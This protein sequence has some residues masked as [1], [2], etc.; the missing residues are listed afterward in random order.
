M[1]N[2][3]HYHNLESAEDRFKKKFREKTA[4]NWGPEIELRFSGRP[5]KYVAVFP[6]L[7]NIAPPSA[8]AGSPLAATPP[9]QALLSFAKPTP[10][11]DPEMNFKVPESVRLAGGRVFADP[12][13]PHPFLWSAHLVKASGAQTVN[14]YLQLI[15][16]PDDKLLSFFFQEADTPSGSSTEGK[17]VFDTIVA[18]KAA[19]CAKFAELTGHEWSRDVAEKGFAPAP[20]RFALVLG[21]VSPVAQTNVSSS[22]GSLGWDSHS[23]VVERPKAR[24]DFAAPPDIKT[25]ATVY[26]DETG[27]T[28]NAMLNQISISVN[29][30]KFY[31]LQLVQGKEFTVWRRWGRGI[32]LSTTPNESHE[33]CFC[34]V[35]ENGQTAANT[36]SSLD[37]A[38]GHFSL[39][40]QQKTGTAWSSASAAGHETTGPLY[41]VLPSMDEQAPPLPKLSWSSPQPATGSA[42]PMARSSPVQDLAKDLSFGGRGAANTSPASTAGSPSAVTSKRTGGFSS[43]SS[44][45]SSAPHTPS[46][47]KKSK[48]EADP[49]STAIISFRTLNVFSQ[50]LQKCTLPPKSHIF[51]AIIEGD[52]RM[53]ILQGY[54]NGEAA[55]HQ[56]KQYDLEALELN[57]VSGVKL[58]IVFKTPKSSGAAPFPTH[59]DPGEDVDSEVSTEASQSSR[60][61]SPTLHELVVAVNTITEL[62]ASSPRAEPTEQQRFNSRLGLAKT[63]F[64]D[65]TRALLYLF[66]SYCTYYSGLFQPLSHAVA[67]AAKEIAAAIP[68]ILVEEQ[69]GARQLPPLSHTFGASA[70]SPGTQVDVLSAIV[71]FYHRVYYWSPRAGEWK[72]DKAQKHTR[73]AAASKTEYTRCAKK[74]GPSAEAV[75]GSLAQ[76]VVHPAL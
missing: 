40:F 73:Q 39:I 36:Y 11:G 71:T 18:G 23:D 5:G 41:S 42:Q 61:G 70:A 34:A 56:L 15:S 67:D 2:L 21:K 52:V 20:G 27:L 55:I 28:Y 25:G 33:I 62:E 46:S 17:G 63:L 16:R 22:A 3:E 35:G 57:A 65:A 44:S 26:R 10:I 54:T 53:A 8:A 58:L 4:N 45:P 1:N 30:N 48:V 6:E 14:A 47:G 43:P 74:Y 49:A 64:G 7:I 60:D 31:I 32:F 51:N 72:K 59:G 24:I 69:P 76:F 68:P 12:G 19:F 75:L 66:A 37:Q 9:K 29:M 38:K 50:T 13:Q